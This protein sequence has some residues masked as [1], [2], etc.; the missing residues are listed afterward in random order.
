MHLL[1]KKEI[2]LFIANSEDFHNKDILDFEQYKNNFHIQRLIQNPEPKRWHPE[3]YTAKHIEMVFEKV[4][5]QFDV[6]YKDFDLTE[7]DR[8]ILKYAAL[9]HDAWKPEC[10]VFKSDGN[11]SSPGHAELAAVQLHHFTT[12][13]KDLSDTQASDLVKVVAQHMGYRKISH[14]SFAEQQE[15]FNKVNPNLLCFFGACDLAGRLES[16]TEVIFE[17]ARQC[18]H[19]YMQEMN[20]TQN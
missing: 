11:P 10:L 12:E 15:Y 1:S 9:F 18:Y 6:Y 8:T 3:G 16:N 19:N 7:Q 4:L 2:L 13:L 14:S 17:G 20:I 5:C